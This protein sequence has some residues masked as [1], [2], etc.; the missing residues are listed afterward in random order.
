MSIGLEAWPSQMDVDARKLEKVLSN[1]V[2]NAL[3][4]TPSGGKVS[5]LTRNGSTGNLVIEVSDNGIGIAGDSLTRILSPFEQGDTSI[6]PRYGGVGLGLSIANTLTSALGGTLEIE[7]DGPGR[8]SK[9]TVT[10]ATESTSAAKGMAQ[11]T[12]QP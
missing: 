4:F 11:D 2:G 1:R 12:I 9:F 5:I 3:K 8:G 6:H 7:S 10:F